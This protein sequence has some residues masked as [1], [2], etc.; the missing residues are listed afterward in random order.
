MVTFRASSLLE[1]DAKLTVMVAT[2]TYSGDEKGSSIS[3]TKMLHYLEG[4]LLCFL[5]NLM[6]RK[7][8]MFI[9][10][11]SNRTRRGLAPLVDRFHASILC[12][13]A[14]SYLKSDECQQKAMTILFGYIRS[15]F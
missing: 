7:N 3:M 8:S 6:V 11:T 9:T 4:A 13:T 5:T 2:R 15:H 1:D 14:T 10:E 12:E